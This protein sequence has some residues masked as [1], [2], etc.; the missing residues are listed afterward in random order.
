LASKPLLS[1]QFCKKQGDIVKFLLQVEGRWEESSLMLPLP[2]GGESRG[3]LMQR[4]LSQRECGQCATETV[5]RSEKGVRLLN[6]WSAQLGQQLVSAHACSVPSGRGCS[7]SYL[8]LTQKTWIL[9]G[10]KQS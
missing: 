8:G 3:R 5:L 9:W 2:L 1:R 4:H 10:K 7:A 6:D